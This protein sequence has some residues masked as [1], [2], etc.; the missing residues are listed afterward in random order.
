MPHKQLNTP[1]HSR[2]PRLQP[3]PK[4]LSR[5]PNEQGIEF[6]TRD[7]EE[8]HEKLK[9]RYMQK[10]RYLDPLTLTTLGLKNVTD[11][12]LKGLH[13]EDFVYS[14]WSTYE[15]V[16]LEFLNTLEL[17]STGKKKEDQVLSFR[18]CLGNVSYEKIMA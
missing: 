15:R 12:L 13:M 8:R 7:Q 17:I 9:G 6:Q 16:M 14:R 18:F 10:T 2:V 4:P 1:K 11:A 3:P 5:Q